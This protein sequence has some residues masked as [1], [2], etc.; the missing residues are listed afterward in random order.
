MRNV[1]EFHLAQDREIWR[2]CCR[3][4]RLF[5]FPRRSTLH[6]MELNVRYGL[7]KNAWV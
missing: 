5:K 7:F 1:D 3:A 6:S 2:S 4:E